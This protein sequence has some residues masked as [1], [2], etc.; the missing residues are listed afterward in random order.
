MRDDS[1]KVGLE[2]LGL[3]DTTQDQDLEPALQRHLV[4]KKMPQH[5]SVK[6]ASA[7]GATPTPWRQINKQSE[8]E[9]TPQAV[10]LGDSTKATGDVSELQTSLAQSLSSRPCDP[11]R[12]RFV[13]A[14]SGQSDR[15]L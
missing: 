2:E 8:A 15:S 6:M 3:D 1:S 7:P 11:L 9:Q 10:G 12:S 4:T 13:R 14:F 5:P